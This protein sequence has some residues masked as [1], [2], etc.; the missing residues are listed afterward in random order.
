[1]QQQVERALED[2]R[3]AP[4]R[5]RRTLV[6]PVWFRP[7][8]RDR[9]NRCGA[10]GRPYDR[11]AMTRVFSGI[12]PTGDVHLGNL[13]GRAAA[14]G[15]RPAPGRQRSSAWSTSTPS[16]SPRTPPSCATRT[17]RA[18]PAPAGRRPRPRACAPCS[19]RATCPSTPSWP[20]SW[21][22]RRRFGELQPHDPVQGQVRQG[23]LRVRRAVHLPGADGGRHPPL[24]HRRVPVGDDQR[25][26]L[27][28]ARDLAERF[29]S[30]YGETFVVPEAAIPTAGARVMDLQDPDGEDVEV[31]RLA[32]GH[33]PRCSTTR[34]SIEKKIKRAVTDTETEV[35]YDS[36]AKPGVSNLLSILAAATGRDPEARRPSG[37]TQYGPLKADTAAAV[38][39]LPAPDPG[40]LRRAGRRP[41][42]DRSA[43][44]PR[45]PPRPGAGAG[46]PHPG[47]EATSA[48]S[49]RPDRQRRSVVVGGL[50]GVGRRR[51]GR[52]TSSAA[53]G[54]RGPRPR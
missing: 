36:A 45:A 28:L 34:R 52:S 31:R 4:R 49:P 53:G 38:V 51:R 9:R 26:H 44:S 18:G 12:Q 23:R 39:E 54:A 14:L 17:L 35:R 47:P 16:R 20:G 32:P 19:C 40:P 42:R 29:N 41:G 22:A 10:A 48:S 7:G 43:C 21:S 15:R 11:R 2:R 25:Q 13:P 1:M 33:D 5:P 3:S 37:Y 50:E 46:H 8:H 6:T 24:R 27:E 30:R